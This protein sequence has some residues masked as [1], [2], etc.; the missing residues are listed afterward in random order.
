MIGPGLSAQTVCKH[1]VAPGARL[2][3]LTISYKGENTASVGMTARRVQVLT[4]ANDRMLVRDAHHGPKSF[5]YARIM[6]FR[7]TGSGPGAT[8][9]FNPGAL[10][11][12]TTPTDFTV[13]YTECVSIP[14][15]RRLCRTPQQTSVLNLLQ[16]TLGLNDESYQ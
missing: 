14:A 10:I 7:A 15:A 16:S 5:L 4:V 6:W 11:S 3:R 1:G 2:T 8:Q 12:P 13:D 9:A